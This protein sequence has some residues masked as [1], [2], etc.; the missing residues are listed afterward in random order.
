MAVICHSQHLL[1]DPSSVSYTLLFYCDV[2]M[3]CLIH[4]MLFRLEY[5]WKNDQINKIPE[6]P[7]FLP[8]F[9][10]E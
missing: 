6:P 3:I 1:P 5:K 2:S 7:R 10:N 9:L 8:H 4:D